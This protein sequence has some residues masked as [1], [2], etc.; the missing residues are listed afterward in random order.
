MP[1]I[2]RKDKSEVYELIIN[3]D[4]F[5]SK[6]DLIWW[7]DYDDKGF[8]YYKMMDC[9]PL[10][11]EWPEDITVYVTGDHP[12]D[13]F[14]SG[15]YYSVVSDQV[16]KIITLR[17]PDNAEFLPITVIQYDS[18]EKFGPYWV[19]NVV[20]VLEAL[21]E[22]HT[23]WGT[24]GRPPPDAS[25]PHIGIIKPALNKEIVKN[26]GIFRISVRGHNDGA[27]HFV[28]QELKEALE[29]ENASLGMN[30]LPVKVV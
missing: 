30:F 25:W 3:G 16:R 21:N 20:K 4:L 5:E 2:K 14:R 11:N 9:R 7:R 26:E 22:E 24:K 8:D 13:I 10:S 15:P 12:V 27:S 28:S 19:I 23:N 17:W 6:P 29:E 18:G 1:K